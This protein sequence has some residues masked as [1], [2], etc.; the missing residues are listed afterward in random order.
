M[1]CQPDLMKTLF[2]VI[3]LLAAHSLAAQPFEGLSEA[4]EG[5]QFGNIKAVVISR[6][7]EIIYEDYFRGTNA[8]TH[9]QVQSVTKSIGSALIG[10]AHRKGEIRLDQ[11][12][13]HFFSGLYPMN[14]GIFL[15]KS[16][17]TVQQV[18][19]QRHGI[20]WDEVSTD[21]R[22][23]QNSVNQM[24]NSNDWYQYVLTQQM[25]TSPG[26]TFNYS[27]GASTLMSRIIRVVSDMGP[28]EFARTELFDALEFGPVHWEGYS[29]DGRG[30]GMTNWPNPDGDA[31]LGF[32][33]WLRARDMVKFGE[34]YLNRG[35]YKDRRILDQDWIDASWVRYSNSS[36]SS[37]F[38]QPGRGHGYQWWVAVTEDLSGR[39]WHVYFASGWGSQVIFVIPELN[40]VV[41]ATADNYDYNGPDVDAMLL[42]RILPELDPFL[43][44]RF[45]GSWYN[46]ATNRQGF[47][48][49]VLDDREEVVAYW[50]TYDLEGNQRWFVL[51]GPV[52]SGVGEVIIYSTSG[53]VFLQ[54]DLAELTEWGTGRFEPVDCDRMDLEVESDVEGISTTIPLTRL[55]GTCFEPPELD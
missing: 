50:Y 26:Q 54:P 23:P 39:Q 32:G 4:I 46:P 41:V 52:V 37:Y 49:E 38:S 5:G 55:S 35:V 1:Y 11:G 40:L 33:L 48:V 34:L 17:I 36:N 42:T 31:S 12:L 3:G 29:E 18:L 24:I 20:Q 19:Q 47:S 14:E 16:A 25:E 30:T 44:S 10:I 28:Q 45:N 7:G 2:L 27:T 22:D 9:H 6:H 13:D 51:Q 21:Y 43:D 53:G 8:S 15:D